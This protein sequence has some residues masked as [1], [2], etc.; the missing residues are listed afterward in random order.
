MMGFQMPT[1]PITSCFSIKQFPYLKPCLTGCVKL[2]LI[3]TPPNKLFYRQ[4]KLFPSGRPQYIVMKDVCRTQ[5]NFLSGR[6]GWHLWIHGFELHSIDYRKC[7]P[8]EDATHPNTFH[9][10][11]GRESRGS[12]STSSSCCMLIRAMFKG[13]GVK[14]TI[15]RESQNLI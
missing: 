11:W 6:S 10:L 13:V 12:I 3:N 15:R 1:F 9:Q 2:A 4:P 5:R 14:E 7:L 8:R